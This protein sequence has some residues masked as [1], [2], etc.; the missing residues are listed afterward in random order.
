MLCG[1]RS[2]G[3]QIGGREGLKVPLKGMCVAS[4]EYRV[5]VKGFLQEGLNTLAIKIFP[6]PAAA[7]QRA[8]AYPYSV[9]AM[10]V[11]EAHDEEGRNY[12]D[13]VSY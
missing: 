1:Q 8:S 12:I 13:R 10:Q 11:K 2:G 5:P 7:D 9:P 4:R 3:C 6:A